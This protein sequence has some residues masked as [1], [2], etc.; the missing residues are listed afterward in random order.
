MLPR[1]SRKS[2]QQELNIRYA[3]RCWPV[4]ITTQSPK[5]AVER[6]RLS[7]GVLLRRPAQVVGGLRVGS[8]SHVH[9]SLW[10]DGAPAVL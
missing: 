1:A 5:Q 6:D 3:R 2:G 8:S 4:P 7:A 10:K 9:M